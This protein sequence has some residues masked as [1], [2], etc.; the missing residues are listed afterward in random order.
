[1]VYDILEKSKQAKNQR[2]KYRRH[3][4]EKMEKE[5][6]CP[7]CGHKHEVC[8]NVNGYPPKIETDGVSI[9][10]VYMGQ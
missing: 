8:E 2:K 3:L 7:I 5:G 4:R 9:K 1:M 10:G 6:S